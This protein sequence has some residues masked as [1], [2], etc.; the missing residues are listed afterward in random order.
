MSKRLQLNLKWTSLLLLLTLFSIKP[1]FAQLGNVG[2]II[3][4][5]QT[6]ANTL[7]KA[8]LN[9]LGRG[10]GAGLNSGWIMS[11]SPH[12]KL[13]FDISFRAGMAIVPTS[14]QTFDL[15][16][17]GLQEL[18]YNQNSS[19]TSPTLSGPK[20]AGPNV[21]IKDNGYTIASFNLPGGT[22]F[23]YIPAPMIQAG[24]GLIAHTQLTL[25]YLPKVNA[26]KYGNYQLFGFGLQ[27]GLNQ[28]IPEGKLLPVKLSIMFG[29]TDFK[30]SKDLNVQPEQG[31][32]N[33]DNYDSNTWKG[34]QIKT[35]TKAYTIN[36]L[37]GKNLPFISVYG[38]IGIESSKMT[39]STPG[40]YPI[41]EF[42]SNPANSS[43]KKIGKIDNPINLSIKGEN[44][45]RALVGLKLKLAVFYISANYTISK[46]S[47][48]NV[49]AGFSF[50]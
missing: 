16:N 29:Y 41:T 49:G 46:Y 48:A 25:R 24:I 3:K 26:G 4:A 11:A 43:H 20:T 14:D 15:N 28:Y 31:V 44:S 17:L 47:I 12:K 35:E 22:G 40:S 1:S 19:T 10:F 6:D 42:D 8:Y 33:P 18:Q 38:G 30:A 27:H 21:S 45:F 36:A 34:Q 50:R 2:E 9:P 23:H 5:G 37:V 32:A 13:G 39:A 7:A